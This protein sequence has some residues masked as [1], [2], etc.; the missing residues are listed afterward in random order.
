MADRFRAIDVCS[1][2]QHFEIHSSHSRNA[3]RE[4]K[5]L[6]YLGRKIGKCPAG[7]D[8]EMTMRSYKRFGRAAI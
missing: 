8:G 3:I 1:E 4:H 5:T 6:I 2:S 7:P